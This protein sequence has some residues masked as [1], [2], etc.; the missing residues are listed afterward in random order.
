MRPAWDDLR[1][2]EMIYGVPKPVT[3]MHLKNF[4][5]DFDPKLYQFDSN[6]AAVAID[7]ADDGSYVVKGTPVSRGVYK[8]KARV[9]TRLADAETIQ[10]VTKLQTYLFPIFLSAYQIQLLC[11]EKNV[12]KGCVIK[13]ATHATFDHVYLASK[14]Q[15]LHMCCCVELMTYQI[16]KRLSDVKIDSLPLC[17]CS[18]SVTYEPTAEHL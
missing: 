1:F 11:W 14:V 9:V 18:Q 2:D 3:F 5:S 4:Y 17:T 8:G 10:K 16:M 13:T 12:V 7:T 6:S 15:F